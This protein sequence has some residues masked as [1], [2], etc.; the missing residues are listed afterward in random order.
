MFTAGCFLYHNNTFNLVEWIFLDNA[1]KIR[2]QKDCDLPI[3]FIEIDKKSLFT[4]GEWPWS[5]DIHGK[6]VAD[7]SSLN[8]KSIMFDVF[9]A[10]EQNADT[11]LA[12]F[13]FIQSCMVSDN[14]Y[15][16]I[17]LDV[18][19]GAD[20]A[21][22]TE[23]SF[24]ERFSYPLEPPYWAD[25]FSAKELPLVEP[26]Y[27]SAKSAG[28]IS[29]IEDS[30]GKIRRVPLF[31]EK[32]SKYYPQI[33]LRIFMDNYDIEKVDFPEKGTI[34]FISKT[35]QNYVVPVDSK[36]QYFVNWTGPF[37][38]TFYHCSYIDVLQAYDNVVNGQPG[39]ITIQHG[40]ETLKAD[41]ETFF[42]NK[43]CMV[44]FTSAGLVDQKPVPV[45]NRYPLVGLHA[46]LFENIA[47]NYHFREIS[48]VFGYILMFILTFMIM[49]FVIT[50]PAIHAVILSTVVI[51]ILLSCN[52]WL[53][54][55]YSL[56]LE[57]TYFYFVI[58]SSLISGILFSMTRERRK[59]KEVEQIFKRYVTRDVVDTMLKNPDLLKLGGNRREVSV[60]FCDI[61]HF[62]SLAESLPPEEVIGLL[63]QYF[64]LMIKI[65][66]KYHGTID[67]FIGDCIMA[68]WNAPTPQP[69]HAYL[70]VQTAIEMQHDI[71]QLNRER[72]A[73]NEIT[74]EAGIGINTGEVVVG[75]IGLL[76]KHFQRT[77]YTVIGDDVNLAA[78]LVDLAKANTILISK[79][80]YDKLDNKL[81]AQE[82]EPIKVK[83]KRKPVPIYKI[84]ITQNSTID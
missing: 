34:R 47:E 14:V 9:F 61:R 52:I 6:L 54:S 39:K 69:D 59:K 17:N 18:S 57:N 55:R 70:A 22:S 2:P 81:Q 64:S 23:P 68:F 43:I 49:L 28:H 10:T 73:A 5:R 75:N 42:K 12:T 16:S 65:I 33:A 63:N 36:L 44:G 53:F 29:V 21:N 46:N 20:Q 30:D 60:L 11:A 38:T 83:G 50:L 51:M 37:E 62:T 45:D 67:K 66:F 79:K 80:T 35:G 13:F 31:I 25:I 40:E 32:N 4:L 41:A 3:V 74:L 78:R 82:S 77:E 27:E 8:A 7:L 71:M 72:T 58:V 1:F 24:L 76:E 56:W 84:D 48:P 19:A 26:L 15:L